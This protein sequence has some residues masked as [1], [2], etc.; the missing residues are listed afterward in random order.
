MCP[1]ATGP[2]SIVIDAEALKT[3]VQDTLGE[4]NVLCKKLRIFQREHKSSTK[5]LQSV[6]QTL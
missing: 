3:T 4:I 5:D 1:E 6:R 2:Y